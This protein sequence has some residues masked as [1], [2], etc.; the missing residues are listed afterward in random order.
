MAKYEKDE[1][2]KGLDLFNEQ[3]VAGFD[4]TVN[5]IKSAADL[6]LGSYDE[7]QILKN[8]GFVISFERASGDGKE[9][10]KVEFKAFLTD[11]SD[12]YTS[13]WNKE[14]VFGRMDPITTFKGTARIISLGWDVVS[15]GPAD[16]Q[17]NLTAL[18]RL[19]KMQY[20]EFDK[21][22]AIKS[23][24]L[25]KVKFTNIVRNPAMNDAPIIGAIEG[26]SYKPDLEQGFFSVGKD[27]KLLAQTV[28]MSCK[29]IVLHSH[30]LGWKDGG[31]DER[32][33]FSKFPY[34]VPSS[35]NASS[36]GTPSNE[37]KIDAKARSNA[38]A[39]EEM[40]KRR[41]QK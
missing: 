3:L 24:P 41:G 18:S 19:I 29:V 4:A 2:A 15:Y 8:N 12:Q 27:A 32:S 26:F 5:G 23:P 33:G 28:N 16:A 40:A 22:G 17:L 37:E 13:D 7:T 25:F 35:T 14:E 34:G 36:E 21:D 30:K 31:G 38:A 9:N 10:S 1:G 20:P 6:L 39:I 11:F